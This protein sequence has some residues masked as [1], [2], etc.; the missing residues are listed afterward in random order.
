[1]DHNVK[2]VVTV[3]VV[4][5]ILYA[6]RRH[7]PSENQPSLTA[8]DAE[9][10]RRIKHTMRVA[11]YQH[12]FEFRISKDA[13]YTLNKSELNLCTSCHL[14][15]DPESDEIDEAV[16]VGLHEAAHVI[17]RSYNHT[18]EWDNIMIILVKQAAELGY[19]NPAKV[20][21]PNS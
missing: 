9:I 13:S 21:I 6:L 16:Y 10:L 11:G 1:M 19:L 3:I 14:N 4:L 17:S 2:I 7:H 8:R 12:Q 18:Q 15:D 20:I 5:V